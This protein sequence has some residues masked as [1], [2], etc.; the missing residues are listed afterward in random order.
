L[1][2]GDVHWL[3][4]LD[5]HQGGAHLCEATRRQTAISFLN[6]TH[7]LA[8]ANEVAA[9]QRRLKIRDGENQAIE[10]A[11]VTGFTVGGPAWQK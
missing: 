11:R 5:C 7:R 6:H 9:Y 1:P 10:A 4:P 8:T 2:D 3:F